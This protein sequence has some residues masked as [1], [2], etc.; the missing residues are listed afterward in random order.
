MGFAA[1]AAP[2]AG[3]TWHAVVFAPEALLTNPWSPALRRMV[4]AACMAVAAG[5]LLAVLLGRFLVR[6]AGSLVAVAI[7]GEVPPTF[8]ESRVSEVNV[9]R[10]ALQAGAKAA[11]ESILERARV[12][13]LAATATVLE[14]RVAERTREL[15]ETTGRLLNAQDEERRRIARE[16]HDSTVQELVAASLN[17]KAA[18]GSADPRCAPELE[19]ARA[20][21]DRAKDELRTV[22]FLM[23]PPMLDECG[24]VT[25][26]RVY[27]EGFSRRSGLA[28]EID[29]PDADPV[30][31]RAL[32]SALF[33]VAQEALANVHRHANSTTARVRLR[34]IGT[35]AGLE[36]EDDGV[37]IAPG[38]QLHV[39][40]GIT[41]MRAR[42]RQFGGDL[43]IDSRAA[44]TLV[45]VRIPLLEAAA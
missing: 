11:H 37:G 9:L 36:I 7:A 45:K 30:L 32:E 24:V 19:E 27:V 14:A 1:A 15:E 12:A 6:E 31:P 16:L 34:V 39:G 38:E 13:S 2:I 5:T 35:E 20:A 41:G 33:R 3:T 23:Q 4:I 21:L 28:I 25:A 8:E 29:A 22:S 40:A 10:R 18:Q 44:G 42:V 43:S 17:L 26:L